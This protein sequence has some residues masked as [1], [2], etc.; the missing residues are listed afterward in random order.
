MNVGSD[1]PCP[2]QRLRHLI[3]DEEW[4]EVFDT[5][6][7]DRRIGHAN[8]QHRP[9]AAPDQISVEVA[10]DPGVLAKNPIGRAEDKENGQD[11]GRCIKAE[12]Q[13][14]LAATF[15]ERHSRAGE[16][17][18]DDQDV[19]DHER[20]QHG[21]HRPAE[22]PNQGCRI[23]FVRSLGVGADIRHPTLLSC[24]FGTRF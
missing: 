3:V 1:K 4:E 21:Q 10:D 18:A 7:G 6:E 14:S 23:A 5:H 13:I 22:E 20:A 19:V 17:E 15:A 2:A 16:I 24:A 9:K 8:D 12:L 11:D